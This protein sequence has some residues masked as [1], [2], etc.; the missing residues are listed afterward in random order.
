MKFLSRIYIMDIVMTPDEYRDMLMR[1]ISLEN[2][3]KI[4]KEHLIM[5]QIQV[6][7]LKIN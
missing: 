7:H 3:I 4:I 1:I 5:R 2:S 6:P